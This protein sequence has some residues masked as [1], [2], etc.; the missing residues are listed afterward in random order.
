MNSHHKATK[1]GSLMVNMIVGKAEIRW[2]I[3]Q[4]NLFFVDTG[5]IRRPIRGV[6]F[7]RQPPQSSNVALHSWTGLWWCA[8]LI[9]PHT[10]AHKAVV[11]PWSL[12]LWY[13]D[14]INAWQNLEVVVP[15]SLLLWYNV[16]QQ[17]GRRGKVV[18]PWS[19]LLW[20]NHPDR[21]R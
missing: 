16:D 3:L 5:T 6:L 13:N 10:A 12:L 8:C 20:Y 7:V 15:W 1:E 9:K 18:V 21:H 2:C 4:Y 14:D 17:A 19:L 11:V